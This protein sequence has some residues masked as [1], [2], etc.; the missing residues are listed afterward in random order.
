MLT[1]PVPV[2]AHSAA[3]KKQFCDQPASWHLPANLENG[4]PP[5]PNSVL[6]WPMKGHI[7]AEELAKRFV[8]RECNEANTRHQIIDRLLHEILNWPHENVACEEKVH[9]GY[10]DYVLRDNARRPFSSL[11]Q[12]KKTS[13][14]PCH[15]RSPRT[16]II[17][18][19]FG[20]ERWQPTPISQMRSIRRP[21]CPEIGCQYA[22]VTNGHEFIIF[23]S[24]I[25]GRHFLDADALVIPKL[26]FFRALFPRLQSAWLP[27]RNK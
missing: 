21:D 7:I 26:Q 20:S 15:P 3:H 1:H 19:R 8:D 6:I 18:A 23:R 16:P 22:C 2:P 9:P 5:H 14:S 12:R 24:F 25:P 27:S 17:F 10:I 13:I 4:L 11:R